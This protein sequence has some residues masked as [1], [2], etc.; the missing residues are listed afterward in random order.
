MDYGYHRC[1]GSV[2]I[3]LDP[4]HP[5]NPWSMNLETNGLR[6]RRMWRIEADLP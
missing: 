1:C 4:L 5:L 3:C 6:I 2:Q